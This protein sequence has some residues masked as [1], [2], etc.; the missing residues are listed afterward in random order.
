MGDTLTHLP[1]TAA[2][3]ELLHLAATNL[4]PGGSLA[5]TFRDYVG[6]ELEDAQRFIPVRSDSERE[7]MC[8]LE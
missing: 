8:F 6:N 4:A 5:L 7:L 1:T 3:D 2:V